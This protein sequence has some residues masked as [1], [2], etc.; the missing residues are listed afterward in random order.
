MRDTLDSLLCKSKE[1]IPILVTPTLFLP[2]SMMIRI[3]LENKR[4]FRKLEKL[5]TLRH[6]HIHTQT[7]TDTDT[8][9]HTHTHTHTSMDVGARTQMVLNMQLRSWTWLERPQ[10]TANSL[11]KRTYVTSK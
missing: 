6:R 1:S 11:T 3:C 2:L 5:E 8:D 4:A 7:H 9:T 10:G